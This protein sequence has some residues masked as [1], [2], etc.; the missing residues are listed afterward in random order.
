MQMWETAGIRNCSQAM[1]T[2][3][4]GP[5]TYNGSHTD[6]SSSTRTALLTLGLTL[7]AFA[8]RLAWALMP[9]AVHW[10]EPDYLILARNLL[11]GQGYQVYGLPELHIPPIGPWLATLALSLGAPV[12]LAMS[13]WHV[14][15]GAL[16]CGLIFATARE[17][18]GND[19]AA[20]LAALLAAFSPALVV[21]PL[22]WG[23][24]TE[25]LFLLALW[26]GIWAAW[27]ML[28]GPS[29]ARPAG[30][31][32]RPGWQA[33]LA[34]GLAFGTS[35]LIR[36]EGLLWWAALAAVAVV[37][38]IRRWRQGTAGR[39][40][41]LLGGGAALAVYLVAFLVL[42]A[43]YWLY[44]YHYTGQFLLSGKT[45]ITLLQA[46]NLMGDVGTTLDSSGDE[47]LWLSP[48]R[49]RIGVTSVAEADPVGLLRRFVANVRSAPGTVLS[50][51]IPL[52]LI[53]FI[54][55][56]LWALPWNRRRLKAEGFW[57]ICLLPLLIVPL[58]H[59]LS[60]LL[61]PL[62]PIALVW[63][64]FGVQRLIAW[65]EGTMTATSP[66]TRPAYRV[67]KRLWPA[68]VIGLLVVLSLRGQSSAER[69]GQASITPSHKEAG[70][71]LAATS[72]LGEGIM[73]RNTE[74]ALYADRAPVDFPN[75]PLDQVLSYARGH[76]AHY[77]VVDDIELSLL[78]PQLAY[79]ADPL[80]TPPE[81]ERL[82]TFPGPVRTT[83]VFRVIY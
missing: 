67:A 69:E 50:T 24:M 71:W 3:G 6:G 77:L 58:T 75:A 21:R 76:N 22:Y 49:Y 79:L 1:L 17:V 59:M 32:G 35:Y 42:A 47:V 15:A 13:L 2:D 9:R 26:S 40:G 52:Y 53:A 33:G 56:G 54:A 62:V 10:D 80:R 72:R 16:L 81:L 45:G 25:S 82:A 43:P 29:L 70:L 39:Q 11:R 68:L 61:L 44:L 8:I 63:A 83:Y 64:G 36:P 46:G 23:S 41:I 60:R 38:V 5:L 37:L 12:D 30:P 14:L 7:A 74:I 57:L 73:T 55:L 34:A 66:A 27:R 65:G 78:R 4:G 20:A 28:N 51:L 18:T 31:F 19:S 48:E